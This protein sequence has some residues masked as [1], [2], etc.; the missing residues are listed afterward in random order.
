MNEEREAGRRAAVRQPAQRRGRRDPHARQRAVAQA[1]PERLHLSDR[2]AGRRAIRR[3]PAHADALAATRGVGMSG[4]AAL[5][6]AATASTPLVAFCRRVARRAPRRSQFDTDGVVIKLDDLALREQL[7]TTAK[8]PR[9]AVAFKFPAEQATTRLIRIDVNVGRTGAVTPFAVLEPVRARA[10]RRSRWRR[11]TTS[12]KSR[13]ATS[14]KATA[15]CIEKGRRHHPEGR[16]ARVVESARRRSADV[17]DADG[18]PV[19]RQRAGE[20]R[21]RGG[22]AVR[23]R[24]RA[25]RASAADSSTSPRAAR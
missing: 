14:A 3:S 5:A 11:C 21:R 23:E 24:R 20:T 12:R 1:R 15:S 25:R 6:G 22:L 19:L 10:A 4:R 9:W 2:H 8:F 13:A 16:R 17:A 18:V 7:G